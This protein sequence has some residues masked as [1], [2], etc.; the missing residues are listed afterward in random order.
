MNRKDFTS[1][2]KDGKEIT[3]SVRRPTYDDLEQSDKIY[4]S[5]V[6]SLIRESGGKKGLLLRSELDKF[7][8][9]TGVWTEKEEQELSQIQ[10]DIEVL[11]GKMKKGGI[12]L[13]EG[14]KL[15][16]E[17][18]DKRKEMVKIMSKRQIFDDSTIESLAERERNDYIVYACT[19][20]SE[21]GVNY[22]ESFDD[23]KADKLSDVY[24]KAGVAS[25]EVIYG[26]NTEFEKRLPENRWLKKYNFIDDDLNYIDRK[27]GEKVD[28]EGKT[29]KMLEE[30]VAKQINTLQGE[31]SEEQPFL[32]EDGTPVVVEEP[33]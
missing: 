19:V 16:I 28:R 23:M 7:L 9:E 20:Y 13:S 1:F 18:T 27:T 21:T 32:D 25:A 2:D 14:R 4:A 30:E 6:A 31:I 5:K 3:L 12:K 22:W 8:K 17:V 29:V 33:K 26:V 24:R 10:E 15:A 11:L